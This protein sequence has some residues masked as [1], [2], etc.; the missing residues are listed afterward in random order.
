MRSVPCFAR[1]TC[2][3][4]VASSVRRSE[5]SELSH[6]AL[7][8]HKEDAKDAFLPAAKGDCPELAGSNL[9]ADERLAHARNL[10][11]FPRRQWCTVFTT[12]ISEHT[13]CGRSSGEPGPLRDSTLPI[14]HVQNHTSKDCATRRPEPGGVESTPRRARTT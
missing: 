11:Q 5:E 1:I 8:F 4:R 14:R 6:V 10:C 12:K 9:A 2:V 13:I 3:A 7:R